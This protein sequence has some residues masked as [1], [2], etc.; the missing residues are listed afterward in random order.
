MRKIAII[1]VVDSGCYE[2]DY[3]KII[4]SITDWTSVNDEDYEFLRDAASR[5]GGYRSKIPAFR[6]IERPEDEKIF[7]ANTV[8]EY[9]RI[10]EEE[11]RR[12]EVEK[13]KRAAAYQKK[14][15]ESAAKKIEK[16]K[17]DL[18][19]LEEGNK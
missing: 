7:I 15:E 4:T 13:Q 6:I 8:A 1:Q 3:E 11:N 18:A 10:I 16:L 9:K 19:K 14:K 17:R 2:C 12:I 5:S